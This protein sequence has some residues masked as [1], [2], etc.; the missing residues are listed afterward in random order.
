MEEKTALQRAL[1]Q[2]GT[3]ACLAGFLRGASPRVR[4]RVHASEG[5]GTALSHPPPP[6]SV[7]SPAVCAE[8]NLVAELIPTRTQK[9]VKAYYRGAITRATRRSNAAAAAAAAAAAQS[10]SV[11]ASA[12]VAAGAAAAGG[13]AS[14]AG[15]G[16]AGRPGGSDTAGP[17][18]MPVAAGA[19]QPAAPAVGGG[20]PPTAAEPWVATDQVSPGGSP[21]AAPAEGLP[22]AAAAPVSGAASTAA[23]VSRAGDTGGADGHSSGAE[24]VALGEGDCSGARQ[25]APEQAPEVPGDGSVRAQEGGASVG[26]SDAPESSAGQLRVEQ[27]PPADADLGQ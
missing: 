9:Q 5:P 23:A 14:A 13:G 7:P 11:A 4:A 6:S 12:G 24:S 20:A 22:V 1:L 16:G 2:H 8:W 21:A 15:P 27:D 25:A 3:S 18:S 26:A 19:S 10:G 17:S